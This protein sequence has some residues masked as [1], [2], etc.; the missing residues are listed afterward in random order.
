MIRQEV[1][2]LIQTACIN[3]FQ[4]KSKM[5]QAM[6]SLI[7]ILTESYVRSCLRYKEKSISIE[8]EKSK[9]NRES[10]GKY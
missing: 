1:K 6:T 2:Q 7:K 9:P 10:E 4:S 5:F 3:L 8:L